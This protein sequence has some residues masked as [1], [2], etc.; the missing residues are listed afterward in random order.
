MAVRDEFQGEGTA[1]DP[2]F[3]VSGP[4]VI[5]ENIDGELI[6]VHMERGTYFSTDEVGAFIWSLIEAQASR[7]EII[8]AAL[9]TYEDPGEGIAG[10]VSRFLA[11]LLDE[12][13]VAIEHEVDASRTPV[14][15]MAGEKRPFVVPSLQT[16]QDMQDMLS[17]DPIHDVEAAGW[18]VPKMDDDPSV[19]PTA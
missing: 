2:V 3:R 14:T 10:A 19:T 5:F 13:L 16:Y 17:L 12:D 1:S 7:S 8:R 15:T 18:P 11:R 6:L 9:D 4:R